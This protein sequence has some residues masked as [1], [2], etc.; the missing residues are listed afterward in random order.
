MSQVLLGNHAAVVAGRFDDDTGAPVPLP[1]NR[2]T[3]AN[4]P[5][6]YTPDEQFRAI[7][8]SRADG[9]YSD[10][11]W[12]SH[13]LPDAPAPKWVESDDPELAQ[14]LGTHFG[15]PVARPK[16]WKD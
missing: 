10:G 2:I 6:S 13:S 4:I 9:A 14:R 12:N 16:S 11:V 1:G 5:D 15:C 7:T 8:A 3:V